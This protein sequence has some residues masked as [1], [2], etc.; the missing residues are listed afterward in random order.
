MEFIPFHG[1]HGTVPWNGTWNQ[2]LALATYYLGFFL[3][4]QINNLNCVRLNNL[5]PYDKL[6]SCTICLLQFFI[7]IY[8]MGLYRDIFAV[9]Y[10]L[11]YFI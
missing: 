7:E 5:W 9:Q 8:S 6:E 11:Y 4:L 2:S 1:F 10:P 3:N